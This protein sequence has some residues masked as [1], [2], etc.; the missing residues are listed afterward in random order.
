MWLK[1]K[2]LISIKEKGFIATSVL[3]SL[4]ALIILIFL[5]VLSNYKTIRST[6]IESASSAKDDLTRYKIIYHPTTGE[7][8]MEETIGYIGKE[9]AL[10]K[11]EFTKEYSDFMGW[12]LNPDSQV[13]DFL[14]EEVVLN[15]ANPQEECHLY[16]VWK[17]WEY[18]IDF[19]SPTEASD[20][21]ETVVKTHDV[22]VNL[23]NAIPK[24]G[25]YTFKGWS[26]A[27]DGKNANYQRNSIFSLNED[28][29]LYAVWRKSRVEYSSPSLSGSCSGSSNGND[30]GSVSGNTIQAIFEDA[31]Y[32]KYTCSAT[33]YGVYDLSDYD[34]VIINYST[35][36]SVT[37]T[38]RI[39]GVS[40][41]VTGHGGSVKQ[42]STTLNISN[43]TGSSKLYLTSA[44]GFNDTQE[45]PYQSYTFRLDS[46][47]FSNE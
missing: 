46:I 23:P 45:I 13:A 32:G 42:Y 37:T 27:E 18:N 41:S 2:K 21:P 30:R 11:N 38:I 22:D 25:G 44:I 17:W 12:S 24:K 15:L 9:V 33:T 39:G 36:R 29:T 8:A 20:L 40:T 43:Q 31:G 35:E 28:T 47:I 10:S 4:A 19:A 16:A 3:Y 1:M 14:D 7:G 6:Q 34:K 5:V 26:L